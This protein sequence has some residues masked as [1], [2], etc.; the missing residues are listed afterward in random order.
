MLPVTLAIVSA[1]HVDSRAAQIYSAA[2]ANCVYVLLPPCS[3]QRVRP[4]LIC[5][6]RLASP[7][8]SERSVPR[9]FLRRCLRPVAAAGS[10]F[11][12]WRQHRGA[13]VARYLHFKARAKGEYPSLCMRRALRDPVREAMARP[14]NWLEGHQ[15]QKTDGKK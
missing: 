7:P 8:M 13:W 4:E 5:P 3:L 12:G 10:W 15:C 9:E 11:A 2:S 6:W 1:A 14:A